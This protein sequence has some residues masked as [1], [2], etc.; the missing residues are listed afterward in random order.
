[1][2]KQRILSLVVLA[3]LTTI[4]AGLVWQLAIRNSRY[5][6]FVA[7]ANAEAARHIDESTETLKQISDSLVIARRDNK[8]VLL[9]FG[10]G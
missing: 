3:V 10:S 8:R 5:S 6:Q 4:A 7:E 1:M 2:S 9:Q